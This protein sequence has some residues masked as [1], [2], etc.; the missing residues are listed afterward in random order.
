MLLVVILAMPKVE[1]LESLRLCLPTIPKS[2]P[3]T[4]ATQFM[5]QIVDG[6]GNRFVLENVHLWK[7]KKK[8]K[9]K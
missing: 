7:T 5:V 3:V 2:C 8:K 9:D 6:R 4:L 1:L